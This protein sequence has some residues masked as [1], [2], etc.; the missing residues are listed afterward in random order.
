MTA[1]AI[2]QPS[3][4]LVVVVGN[5]S[6]VVA[7]LSGLVV[8][9]RCACNFRIVLAIVDGTVLVVDCSNL[10]AVDT[11]AGMAIPHGVCRAVVS[12]GSVVVPVVVLVVL[13]WLGVRMSLVVAVGCCGV[14]VVVPVLV[15]ALVGLSPVGLGMYVRQ[16][17]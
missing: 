17:C 1:V 16:S 13:V 8:V 9:G 4:V 3:G 10:G 7:M 15:A 12:V 14:V 5:L 11:V 6:A 2:V